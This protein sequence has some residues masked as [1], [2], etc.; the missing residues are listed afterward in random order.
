MISEETTMSDRAQFNDTLVDLQ[1]AIGFNGPN[2]N[3]LYY[4]YG[5][6]L[7]GLSAVDWKEIL[8]E[9]DN[10]SAPGASQRR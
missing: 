10:Q 6:C 8:G 9:R 7:E 5:R 1:E 2:G 4:D 3:L